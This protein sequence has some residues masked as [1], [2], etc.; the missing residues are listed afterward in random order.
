M[1]IIYIDLTRIVNV[2]VKN[3]KDCLIDHESG[4]IRFKY[5]FKLFVNTYSMNNHAAN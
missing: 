1:C 2:I 5:W 3:L 4:E